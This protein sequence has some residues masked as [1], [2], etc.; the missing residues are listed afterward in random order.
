MDEDYRVSMVKNIIY[1][2]IFFTGIL[3]ADSD[4]WNIESLSYSMENDT[5]VDI[6]G[7]YTHGGRI[8]V[9]FAREDA[10]KS[11]IHIP[12]TNIQAK[13]HFISFAY[14]NQMYNPYD[15]DIATLIEDDRPYAGWSYIE[16]ALHQV[17]DKNLDSLTVQL[18]VVGPASKMEELQTFFH[19]YIDVSESAGWDNQLSNEVGL[20]VNYMHKWRYEQA[21]IVGI[22][23][24][25]IPY[26]GANLGNISTKASAG[27]MYRVGW[28]I[29]KD[30]GMNSMKEGSYPSIPIH[31]KA[32]SKEKSDWALYLN[33]TTGANFVLRDIF[34]DGNTFRDSHSIDK[35]Y[36]NAYISYGVT[37]RYKNFL[38]EYVHNYYTKEYN[39]RG[40]YQD[41]K[42]YGSLLLTY[43]F[44]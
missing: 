42:G 23:S 30:Y 28:N 24:V 18:G 25:L 14:A 37:A 38:I 15:Q 31:S 26:A 21:D 27:A 33:L 41:Y 17:T 5:D 43:Y 13:E 3:Q 8:S 34:L 2:L 29:S 7:G 19:K 16:L 1:A 39:E 20:Q 9:L 40:R 22:E 6:D 36:L 11:Q 12:F 35:N 10:D 44:N 4:T 32:I